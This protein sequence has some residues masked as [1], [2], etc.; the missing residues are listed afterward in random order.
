MPTF[1]F[2][3]HSDYS[4]V[5]PILFGQCK[6]YLSDYKKVLITNK[7][8]APIQDGWVTVYYDETKP[9]QQRV[10]EGLEQIE[11][12]LIVFHHE[13]MI[14]YDEID[15]ESIE[16]FSSI[17]N[18]NYVYYV[19]VFIKLLRGGEL[20]N[21]RP[22]ESSYRLIYAEECFTIQPTIC[23]KDD[24]M[25]LYKET[26][27][28]TIWEFERN[29]PPIGYKH[30]FKGVMAYQEGDKKRGQAHWDSKVYPF[31]ATAVVKGKWNV[32]EYPE[33]VKLLNEY[34]INPDIRGT[35]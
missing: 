18:T 15:K 14:L 31:I 25:T 2:Y 16:Y 34:E 6:K 35:R 12:K 7:G 11:D 13:D 28:N 24:L 17:V 29:I 21:S 27:G 26:P 33:L 32:S 3:S 10:C 1:V 30:G 20:S 19:G 23:K 4:D 5:W 9:Y 22:A 8:E